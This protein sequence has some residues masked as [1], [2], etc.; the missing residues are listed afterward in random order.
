MS[1]WLAGAFAV[2]AVVVT[3]FS[4]I[5]PHLRGQEGCSGPGAGPSRHAGLDMQVA[6]LRE[7]LRTLKA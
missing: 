2:A 3:Y 7:E 5:R 1:A 4:C 6:E